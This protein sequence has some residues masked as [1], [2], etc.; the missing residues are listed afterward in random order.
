MEQQ[1]QHVRRERVCL[2]VGNL[3]LL[4]DF[5]LIIQVC[6]SRELFYQC[7]SCTNVT[8][9]CVDNHLV[10]KLFLVSKFFWLLQQCCS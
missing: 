2:Y 3:L 10:S 8:V 4:V 6:E 1:Y 5:A 7:F 9:L